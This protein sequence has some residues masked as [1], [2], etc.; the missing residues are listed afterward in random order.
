MCETIFN[1]TGAPRGMIKKITLTAFLIII[2]VSLLCSCVSLPTSAPEVQQ[3]LSF[4]KYPNNPII[5]KTNL[6][7]ENIVFDKAK[8]RYWMVISDYNNRSVGLVCSSDLVNW[9][10]YENNPILTK[11]SDG[12]DDHMVNAPQLLYDKTQ[13]LYYLYYAGQN[14]G[15]HSCGNWVSNSHSDHSPYQK[16]EGSPIFWPSA[17]WETMGVHEPYIFRDGEKETY[18]LFNMG[19]STAWD[20]PTEQV[21]YAMA[22]FPE[23]PWKRFPGNPVL[24]FDSTP[25]DRSTI[26]EPSVYEQEGTYCVFLL[27]VLA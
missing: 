15:Y 11:S 4:E 10:L 12:W 19:N 8:Q 20:A 22:S 26:A 16:Y 9:A 23:G 24:E 2:L 5:P 7:A 17:G 25:Y 3:S 13:G 21:G 6:L 27:L 1:E 14:K 18:I